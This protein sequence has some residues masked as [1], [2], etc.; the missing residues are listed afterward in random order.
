[1]RPP[2]EHSAIYRGVMRHRRHEPTPHALRM[3]L[4]MLYLDL[5][6]LDAVFD[7]RLLWSKRRPA[8]GRWKRGDYFGGETTPLDEAV[9]DRVG[10]ETGRRPTGPI[11]MLTH[12]RHWGYIFNPVTFYYCFDDAGQRVES[13]LAEITNTPWKQRH[14]YVVQ[15]GG[16]AAGRRD[17]PIRGRFAKTFHVSPFMAMQ[18]QYDWTFSSPGERLGVAMRSHERGRCV[19]DATLGLARQ[20]ITGRALNALLVRYPAMTLQVIGKIHYDALRL[21]LKGVPVVAHPDRTTPAPAPDAE[22]AR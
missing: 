6:E 15:R 9:R 13:V 19:F 2:I 11:R 1:M 18:Q 5:A 7:G 8:I 14:A 16:A 3:P 4:C 10:A 20:P 22:R 12:V 21:W 17:G